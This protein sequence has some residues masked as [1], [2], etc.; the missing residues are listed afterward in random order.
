MLVVA[1]GHLEVM[2]VRVPNLAEQ[3]ELAVVELDLQAL[4]EVVQQV[5]QTLAAAAAVVVLVQPALMVVQ[6]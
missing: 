4:V 3:V 2:V 1:A 6:E 5:L